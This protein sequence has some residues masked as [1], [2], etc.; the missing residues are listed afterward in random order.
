[1][2]LVTWVY[3]KATVRQSEY[4]RGRYSTL[5]TES[6]VKV[7]FGDDQAE[8]LR[9]VDHGVKFTTVDNEKYWLGLFLGWK[10]PRVTVAEPR[11]S[12][13]G[14]LLYL[15]WS[16]VFGVVE[17]RVRIIETPPSGPHGG[18]LLVSSQ[19]V[20]KTDVIVQ[21]PNNNYFATIEACN[22]LG[23]GPR[24]T[25]GPLEGA[26]EDR[27]R[28]FLG[29]PSQ[30]DEKTTPVLLTWLSPSWG[31][32]SRILVEDVS[33]SE[34]VIDEHT[35]NRYYRAKLPPHGHWRVRIVAEGD[36]ATSST[37]PVEFWTTTRS[38]PKLSQP[39]RGSTVSGGEV[40]LAWSAVDRSNSY[41]FLVTNLT[42]RHEAA[43]GVTG[44]L[45]ALVAV[46]PRSEPTG[47][48]AIV[49]ACP[50]GTACRGGEDAGW[51]PWSNGRLA[52]DFTVVPN[53]P[54]PERRY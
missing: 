36:G 32:R 27:H 25:V 33:T 5:A 20:R 30:G 49:R 34:T 13:A 1:M 21:R 3:A 44:G 35:A 11:L 50:K 37:Q 28:P 42:D 23:C 26:A 51:G 8:S 6:P 2:S 52:A 31:D 12:E 19:R 43:R 41:E 48:R 10:K 16:G 29:L 15:Q 18:H 46:P 14:P 4:L 53:P 22:H 7:H 17:Y 45:T 54:E 9:L 39:Q 40:T 38:M 47:Y 24:V